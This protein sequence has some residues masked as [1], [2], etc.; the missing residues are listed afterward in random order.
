L[1]Q[2]VNDTS[3]KLTSEQDKRWLIYSVF[4]HSYLQTHR[5][6]DESDCRWHMKNEKY[7][8]LTLIKSLQRQRQHN[9]TPIQHL[10]NKKKKKQTARLSMIVSLWLHYFFLYFHL[11]LHKLK[12]L[13]HQSGSHHSLPRLGDTN[14]QRRRAELRNNQFLERFSS[15]FNPTV[16][17]KAYRKKIMKRFRFVS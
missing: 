4:Y 14:R 17:A 5:L 7:N 12:D 2:W 11:H 9:N 15:I 8:F 6:Y 1:T 3:Y 16:A 10:F 13:T